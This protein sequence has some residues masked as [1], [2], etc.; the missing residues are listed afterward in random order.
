MNELKYNEK[1]H[2]DWAWSLAVKGA[3]E[4]E[5]ADA[6][7]VT[8]MTVSRWKNKYP[9]FRDAIDNAKPIADAKVERSLY[10]RATGFEITE[11][12]RIVEVDRD[13]NT[14][15]IKVRTVTKHIAPDTM[16][17]MYWLNNRRRGEWTQKQEVQIETP[18]DSE[19]DV[20]I[21]LPSNKRQEH[22]EGTAEI[23][24]QG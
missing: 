21:I 24:E 1:Y 20:V 17:I 3:T 13:G 15:P 8:R 11:E 7:H 4:Q 5:I 22:I 2:I 19:T 12:E 6:F 10:Q 16:A 23:E 18:N 14:K 9:E